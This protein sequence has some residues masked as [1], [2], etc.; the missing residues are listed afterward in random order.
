M[1]ELRNLTLVAAE[2]RLASLGL[3]A[4]RIRDGSASGV[5]PGLVYFQTPLPG[6]PVS[7]VRIVLSVSAKPPAPIWVW[8]AAAA[9]ALALLAAAALAVLAAM[10]RVRPSWGP[11]VEA[12]AELIEAHAGPDIAI[13]AWVDPGDSA[14]EGPLPIIPTPQSDARPADG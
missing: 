3:T 7:H 5:P 14:V 10:I 6:Q 1:P 12:D 2:Q 13:Q 9:G 4:A 11:G 8:P